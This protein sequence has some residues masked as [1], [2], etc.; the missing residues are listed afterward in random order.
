[1]IHLVWP[2]LKGSIKSRDEGGTGLFLVGE[3]L[4]RENASGRFEVPEELGAS[5]VLVVDDDEFA[6]NVLVAFLSDMKQDVEQAET[7]QDALRLC[8]S[9]PFDLILLDVHLPDG[10]GLDALPTL[11]AGLGSPEII[12]ITGQGDPNGAELAIRNGAWDYIEKPCALQSMRLPIIRALRHRQLKR[13]LSPRSVLKREGLVGN[14]RSLNACLDLVAQAASCDA[15]VLLTGETGTGKELVARAI[16]ANSAR[17][18][19]ELVVVDC[20]ALPEALVESSLFGYERGAYTGAEKSNEGLVRLADGGT[21]FLDEVGELPMSMQKAFLRVLQ[22]R[23]FRPVGGKSEL[24]SDFR[25][26][27]ATNRNLPELVRQKTFRNDLLYRLEAIAIEL[28][29]LRERIEDIPDLVSAHLERLTSRNGMEPKDFSPAFVR[30]LSAY[31]WPGNVRE[32][33]NAVEKALL[34]SGPEPV[35]EPHHLPIQIRAQAARTFVRES[36]PSE[37]EVEAPGSDD[38]LLSLKQVRDL[39]VAEAERS[40]LQRLLRV[41]HGEIREACQISQLSR[42]QL[43]ALLRKHS[44][45]RG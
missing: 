38:A 4:G 13:E 25:L 40:Y 43:Y 6:G 3:E 8:E 34:A 19:R 17:A 30:V 2:L 11:R 37:A 20:A 36:E 42:A 33:V 22:E 35:L 5:H 10:N 31:D 44:L 1:M 29:P 18:G 9:A 23:K 27:A 26:I 15:S 39:A 24:S 41:T 45:S 16:H 7:L 28:P 21:L 14:S 32:L 12:I